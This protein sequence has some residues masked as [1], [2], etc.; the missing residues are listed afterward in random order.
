MGGKGLLPNDDVALL[1][2]GL[3]L[4]LWGFGVGDG[5]RGV[6]REEEKS[7]RKT[8]EFGAANDCE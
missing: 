2:E 7:K 6:S 4:V 3:E 8:D 1:A 5:D